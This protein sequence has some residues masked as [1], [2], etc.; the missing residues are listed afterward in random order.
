VHFTAD[1]VVY[2]VRDLSGASVGAGHKQGFCIEDVYDPNGADVR[3]QPGRYG[4]DFMGI[5]AG[6]GDVYRIDIPGQWVDVTG[7]P[8]G[9]YVLEVEVNPSKDPRFFE[10]PVWTDDN[11]ASVR[12]RLP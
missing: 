2:R 7:I 9:E 8:P 4:C 12:I 11:V 1:W 6:Y 10:P 5:S 3:G